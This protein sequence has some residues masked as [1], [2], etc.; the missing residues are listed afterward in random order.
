MPAR[1][2]RVAPDPGCA[3]VLQRMPAVPTPPSSKT[4]APDRLRS[5]PP[6]RIPTI[7][8][9]AES[10]ES[11]ARELSAVSDERER[12][13]R[14]LHLTVIPR[15]FA[16]GLSLMSSASRTSE[17]WVGR[18]S[19]RCCGRDRRSDSTAA[20]CHVCDRRQRTADDIDA[21][22]RHPVFGGMT[23]TGWRAGIRPPSTPARRTGRWLGHTAR[24]AR[25]IGG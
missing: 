23:A 12:V 22:V 9:R 11:H 18:S 4:C 1:V 6:A 19:A 15:L 24:C 25:G 5:V 17:P 21:G 16:T 2:S 20:H 14:D 7:Y 10:L 3:S 13:A 8:V